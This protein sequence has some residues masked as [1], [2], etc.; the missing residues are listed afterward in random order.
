MQKGSFFDWIILNHFWAAYIFFR[1]PLVEIKA[2]IFVF[3][4]VLAQKTIC[5]ELQGVQVS[6]M[7]LFLV[8][9]R[10]FLEQS[11]LIWDLV[12]C[13]LLGE[14][15]IVWTRVRDGFLFHHRRHQFMTWLRCCGIHAA[16]LSGLI[17]HPTF[18]FIIDSA[19]TEN[20]KMHPQGQE[21]FVKWLHT[22]R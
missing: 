20:W 22:I 2:L 14:F 17:T 21:L 15:W 12:R 16:S 19:N 8:V 6:E 7:Q 10:L 13:R 4:F 3:S 5:R 18:S 11:L 9:W 1:Q